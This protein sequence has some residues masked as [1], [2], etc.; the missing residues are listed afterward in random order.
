[1]G[2]ELRKYLR[3][4]LA[5]SGQL[6]D[7]K[8]VSAE[9]EENARKLDKRPMKASKDV[10]LHM[11]SNPIHGGFL[12]FNLVTDFEAAGPTLRN[13]QKTIWL[14]THLYNA[15]RRTSLSNILWRETK[16]IIGLYMDELFAGKLPL[17]YIEFY[18]RFALSLGWWPVMFA[19]NPRRRSDDSL[20]MPPGVV[21]TQLKVPTITQIFHQLFK[22][23][24]NL[25]TCLVRLETLRR[26]QAVKQLRE[27]ATLP[28]DR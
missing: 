21:D 4:E 24:M 18:P 23:K 26:D 17:S 20:V 25:E 6:P 22:Q 27:R 14:T 8:P 2:P 19:R 5:K 15:L 13:W 12:A 3:K 28:N 11:K 10:S 9:Y 7:D 16:D 1:M